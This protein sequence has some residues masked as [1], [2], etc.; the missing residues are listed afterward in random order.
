LFLPLL[1]AV[2]DAIAIVDAIAFAIV[3][4]VVFAVAF[5]FWD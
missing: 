3:D 5:V 1:F 2:V 4:A